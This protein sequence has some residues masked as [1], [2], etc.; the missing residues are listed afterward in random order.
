M[1]TVDKIQ[2]K[3]DDMEAIH[4]TCEISANIPIK[5]R[6]KLE[7]EQI[8]TE[9]EFKLD[10]GATHTSLNARDLGIDVSEEEFCKWRKTE[11]VVAK[12]IDDN[13]EIK[14][15]KLQVENFKI[16][17]LDL[18][19]VPIY[20]TFCENMTKRLLGMNLLRLLNIAISGDKKCIYIE[21]SERFLEYKKTHLRVEK[22]ELLEVEQS[23]SDANTDVVIIDEYGK[24]LSDDDLL[25]LEI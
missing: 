16:D 4:I 12:G 13:V 6:F 2:L 22:P 24:E 17:E 5:G 9:R 14:F 8:I 15:Y 11:G 18:G 10:T 20:I 25:D 19:S 7:E 23:S 21:K 1:A 3:V